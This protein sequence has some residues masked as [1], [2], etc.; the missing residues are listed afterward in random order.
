MTKALLLISATA[1][2]TAAAEK[3]TQTELAPLPVPI[4][5]NAV[6]AVR[7]QGQDLVYSFTGLGSQKSSDSITNAAYALN[8]KYNKWSTVHSVPG[9]GR[10]A[11]EAVAVGDEIFLL[12][13]FVP[14]RTG[15]QAIVSDVSVYDPVGLRWYRAP[16]LA[17]PV[18]D[19]VA[20][21]YR[22]RYIY[23]VGGF[24]R[25]GPTNDVQLYDADTKKWMKATPPPGPAVFGHA[26]AV[27]GN[28]IIYVD[29]AKASEGT[30]APH[31]ITSD[32]CWIGRIDRKDPKK[33]EWGKL[34]P[35]PG[36]A[37]YRIAAGGSDRDARAYFAGGTDAIYDYKGIGL[38]KKPAE[39]SPTVF[40][41]NFKTNSWETITNDAPN[42][43]MDHRGL[44]VTS[45]GL[46]VVGGM[47]KDQQVVK[48]V[49]VL[50][51]S[52]K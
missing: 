28:A 4:T 5:N 36:T 1:L 45:A 26:G 48:T 6:T 35:H 8:L 9:T 7:I 3:T 32:E 42:P 44:V 39:P 43:T 19:A 30:A 18:R 25:D 46:L 12:G 51:K 2:L 20:G 49:V 52:N 22:D 17:T 40:A 47:G 29:G 23:V 38:D 34:P 11:A 41:Y 50:P 15:L 13:G 16:D 14:D 10:L 27:V 37:R 24:S 21:V 33:I 31:Y